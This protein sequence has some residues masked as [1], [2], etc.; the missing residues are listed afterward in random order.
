MRTLK[1]ERLKDSP[2]PKKG[3]NDRQASIELKLAETFSLGQ[4]LSITFRKTIT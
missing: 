3:T 2:I 1:Q 4:A